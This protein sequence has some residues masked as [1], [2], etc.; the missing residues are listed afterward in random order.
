MH[1]GQVH[2]FVL[3]IILHV[4]FLH[5]VNNTVFLLIIGSFFEVLV[6]PLRFAIIYLVSGIGGVLLSALV[7]DQLAVGKL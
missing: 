3:P 2:R 6:E 7:N 5:I 4:G 1:N